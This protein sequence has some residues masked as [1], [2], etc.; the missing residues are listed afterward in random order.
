MSISVRDG[1]L[2][3]TIQSAGN[4]LVAVDFMNESCPPCRAIQPWWESLTGRYAKQIVFCTVKCSDCPTESRQFYIT[5]TPTFVFIVKGEEVHRIVGTDKNGIIATLEKYKGAGGF[6]G[7]ARTLGAA[8]PVGDFFEHLQRQRDAKRNGEPIPPMPAPVPAPAPAPVVQKKEI[9]EETKT[10]M[11]EM[12]F[13][14]SLI[15]EAYSATNGGS[16]DAMI[17]FIDRR[18]NGAAPAQPQQ[19]QP[20]TIAPEEVR[21]HAPNSRESRVANDLERP[22]DEAGNAALAELVKMGYNEELAHIAIN[23]AGATNL[24]GCID[25]IG[26]IERGESIPMPK[27]RPTQEELD[28]KMEHYKQLLQQKREAETQKKTAPKAVANAE[29]Q[30]RKEVL[31]NLENRK[32]YEEV[33]REQEKREAEKARIRDKLERERVRQ[34]I[35]AQ[36]AA[37]NK[38]AQPTPTPA[39]TPAQAQAPAARPKPTECTLRLVFPDRSTLTGKFAPSQTMIDVEA[40]VYSSKP[41]LR[42]RSISYEVPFPRKLISNS[43]K[44]YTLEQLELTPRAQLN[45]NV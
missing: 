11:L 19:A 32:K 4:K 15:E 33:K 14:E 26:K 5:A 18:Q 12:G 27:H 37:N 20:R 36:K 22:L 13:D 30:R 44:H 3:N 25:I 1:T 7:P 42:G 45:V 16:V 40:F 8:A 23:V 21:E 10:F 9:P 6:S 43:N 39:P 2:R 35:A 28:E 41:E 34:K 29:L 38:P 31:E 24:P 17:D